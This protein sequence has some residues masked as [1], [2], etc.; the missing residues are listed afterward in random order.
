M[1]KFLFFLLVMFS[2]IT[3]ASAQTKFIPDPNWKPHVVPTIYGGYNF[4]QKSPVM[5]VAV[6]IYVNF[7]RGE[8]DFSY[9][10]FNV[11]NIKNDIKSFSCSLGLQYGNRVRGYAMVGWANW[12]HIDK[13]GSPDNHCGH[14]VLST[15]FAYLKLKGGLDVVLIKGLLLNAEVGYLVHK[16]E[17]AYE[18]YF[19]SISLR[20]GLGWAF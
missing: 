8:F 7:V 16:K 18:Q 11:Y 2:V 13:D 4:S 3:S 10:H 1:K 9:T 14:D 20:V 12:I 15:N 6:P 17:T 5:G 19:D